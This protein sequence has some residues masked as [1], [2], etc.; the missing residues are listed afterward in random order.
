MRPAGAQ[1]PL[2][3]VPFALALPQPPLTAV[4]FALAHPL[5]FLP[6]P[7]CS[8]TLSICLSTY[9]SWSN[10]NPNP[11]PNPIRYLDRNRG[12]HDLIPNIDTCVYA[13]ESIEVL[14]L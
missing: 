5:V 6:P 1:P 8:I 4:P 3:A 13:N 2:A 14:F 7:Q 10:P 11:N 12:L 9:M